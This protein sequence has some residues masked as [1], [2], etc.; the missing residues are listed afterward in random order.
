MRNSLGDSL[1]NAVSCTS[2]FSSAPLDVR[3]GVQLLFSRLSAMLAAAAAANGR[4]D[5]VDDPDRLGSRRCKTIEAIRLAV[6][7]DLNRQPGAVCP[8]RKNHN[9]CAFTPW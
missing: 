2:S 5:R 8:E 6:G 9:E 4:R 3:A 1:G 7:I